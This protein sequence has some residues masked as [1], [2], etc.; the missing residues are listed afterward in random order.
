MVKITERGKKPRRRES[1]VS[2]LFI[3]PWIRKERLPSNILQDPHVLE[4][5]SLP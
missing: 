3:K 5:R 2:N 1:N 4:E